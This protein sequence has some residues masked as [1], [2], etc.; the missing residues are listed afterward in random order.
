MKKNWGIAVVLLFFMVM[1]GVGMV[2]EYIH[3]SAVVQIVLWLAGG[4]LFGFILPVIHGYTRT[5]SGLMFYVVAA[6]VILQVGSGLFS[7]W[8]L[9]RLAEI[10]ILFAAPM[11]GWLIW[12]KIGRPGGK[13]TDIDG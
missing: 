1:L 2:E 13:E 7:G 5:F 10:I 12:D 4:L 9:L 8:T 6:N 3:L 11:L